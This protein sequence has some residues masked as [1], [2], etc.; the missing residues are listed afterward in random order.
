ML[1]DWLSEKN[2]YIIV[3]PTSEK[4]INTVNGEAILCYS[5]ASIIGSPTY[6]QGMGCSELEKK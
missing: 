2:E 4:T 5:L 3:I 6:I 1:L